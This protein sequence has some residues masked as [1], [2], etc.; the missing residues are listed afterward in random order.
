MK[1][2]PKGLD[3]KWIVPIAREV[4]EA[5]KWVHQAGIIHR[6]IKCEH[7]SSLSIPNDF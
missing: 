5:I 4:G 1:P 7:Y 6:D 3:E 2:Q